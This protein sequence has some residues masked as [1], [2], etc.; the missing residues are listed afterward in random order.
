MSALLRP[1]GDE[2]ATVYGAYKSKKDVKKIVKG[3]KL[4]ILCSDGL[5]YHVEVKETGAAGRLHFRHW[6]VK[7]DYIG[8]FDDLYLATQGTYSEGISAQNTY[9]TLKGDDKS[10]SSSIS[11]PVSSNSGTDS[12]PQNFPSGTRYPEDF[13][14]K[15]RFASS[16][17]RKRASEEVDEIDGKK[18]VKDEVILNHAPA[19]TEKV[20]ER[21][22]ITVAERENDLISV[23]VDNPGI[24]QS[25]TSIR[26]RRSSIDRRL[27]QEK[28]MIQEQKKSE[29]EGS[30][31]KTILN[32][33][34]ESEIS[35]IAPPATS[36]E[37][38][39]SSA[40]SNKIH[41][42]TV[43]SDIRSEPALNNILSIA[44]EDIPV[45]GSTEVPSVHAVLVPQQAS[46]VVPVYQQTS[47]RAAQIKYLR[48][49]LST[50][51]SMF[52]TGRAID[53]V[54][55]HP[56]VFQIPGSTGGEG[57]NPHFTAKQLVA[58]LQARRKIDEVIHHVLGTL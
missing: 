47:Q 22:E 12:R 24:Q 45:V 28:A 11:K 42:V 10:K 1:L 33:K 17:S 23:L 25:K 18:K 9:P 49:I 32:G 56:I 21:T 26:T 40:S 29:G 57:M 50:D 13:L 3:D 53:I 41:C 39:S 27:S 4:D 6:S 44:I 37:A 8:S 38:S 46:R 36:A 14:S 5:N 19:K 54:S 52:D 55:N 15:P 43:D 34:I 16:H 31:S 48:E 30:E 35:V 7:H 2:I 51:K 20:S 58:L